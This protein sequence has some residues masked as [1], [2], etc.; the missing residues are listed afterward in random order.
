M[1]TTFIDY[2]GDGNATKPF[3]FPSIQESDVKVEVDEV[4]KTSGVHYNITSYTTTGGGNVV[5]T[6]GNEPNSPS[7]IRIF[8]DTDVDS[9]KATYT[10]GSSVKAADLNDNNEQ[11]LFSAQEEQNQTIQTHKIKD[12]AVT[13][14]KIQDGAIVNAD[15]NASA[16]IAGTKISPDFGSQNIATTGTING[17]TTTELAILDGATVTTAELNI[18]DGVTATTSEVNILDGVTATT[19][20]I[21]K[22]DGV[23]ADTAELNILDGVTATTSELN[24]MDGVTATTSEINTLDGVTATTNELNLLDGVTATT[25]E[26][27]L[28]DGVTAT[29]AELNFVDGVTSNVQTQLDNKQPLDS[30]L[31]TLSGMQAGT[32]SIL[33]DSTALTA[34]TSELNQLDGITLETTLTGTSDQRIPTS[35]AVND[36]ILAVTNALGGF[37]AIANETSF[38][39]ANP[40]PSNGAGTVVSISQIS[41][42]TAVSVSN[43][44]EATISNG[45]GTGNTVTITGFPTTL[46]NTNL[47]ANSGLQ[48]QTTTTLHTYTF[49][50]QLASA[51]DIQAISATVNSFSNRYR[52]SSSAPQSSLDAGDLWYDTTNS[53]LM[54]Y[55]GQNSAWE[56]A[57]AIGNFFISTLSSSSSTGGG[58]A[59]A[60]GTA[61]RF[62]LSDAPTSAQQL[63]VSVDGVIQKPNSGSSQPSEGYVLVGNDIIFS[64]APHNGA[65]I[66][67]TVI[68]STVGIGTPSNNTVTSA[69]LQNGSVITSKLA[70]DAVDGTKI[71]D[72]SINSEHYVDGSID[73]AHIA[74]DQ[75]TDAKLADHGSDDSLRAVGSAHI[76]TNAVETRTIN[77]GAVTSQKLGSMAVTAAAMA[78]DA[79]MDYA[80]SD[81][82]TDNYYR[83]VNTNHIKDS[84]V[85]NAKI[86]ANAAIDGSKINPNFG[87]QNITTAGNIILGGSSTVDGKDVSTLIAN[88]VEDTSPQLGGDLD[89]NDKNIVIGDTTGSNNNRIKIGDSGDLHIYHDGSNSYLAHESGQGDLILNTD[90][91]CSINPNGGGSFGL[92]VITNGSVE[93]YEAGQ[94]K[95]ETTSDGITVTGSVTDSKGDL[96][97]IPASSKSS[98]YTLQATDAGTLIYISSGG[99][100]VP[101]SAFV[102]GQAVSIIN[103]SGS[104]QT[105]TQGSGMTLYNTGDAATGN[106]TLAGRGMATIWFADYNIGYISGAGL[107]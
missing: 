50:K 12:S 45:A 33:A 17:V 88:V 66:F 80:L 8:R 106:R 35:K 16:A 78:N 15:V 44:G 89:V 58:S 3:S 30:E 65:S 61:Y 87:A 42:G 60:N 51:D 11:L 79:V 46:R 83:A 107:S 57:T 5:F 64:A 7:N 73:T 102:V 31:T 4:L 28:V 103:N 6:S 62:T 39:A 86:V 93:L 68:G 36:Q 2:T 13:S 22:L 47:A 99:I 56:E 105:I 38:P 71:A 81:H 94:K 77:N 92:R 25:T 23:T 26:L 84:A 91:T 14:A 54:V 100:T 19:T 95:L 40:D 9:P 101:S 67:V 97:K 24:I 69:I 49:H 1:A 10:A 18:L 59:T 27:N 53:K 52:V 21:N 96:R 82:S 48:V 37:V 34:T 55:S 85:T 63:I 72:D 74:D 76:K 32:A 90:S 104:D 70:T 75:V 41:S 20:E 98:A 29:T 43:T